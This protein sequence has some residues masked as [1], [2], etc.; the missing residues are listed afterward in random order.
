[1]VHLVH[2]PMTSLSGST[3]AL[4]ERHALCV[5]MYDTPVTSAL[6]MT[7]LLDNGSVLSTVQWRECH[8][9]SRTP[10]GKGT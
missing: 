8:K 1:M 10:V 3:F 9:E 4:H 2:T 6:A 7:V 5:P